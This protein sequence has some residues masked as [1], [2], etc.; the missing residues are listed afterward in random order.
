[1]RGD[2]IAVLT[3]SALAALL[4]VLMGLI[5]ARGRRSPAERER[6]RRRVLCQQGRLAEATVIDIQEH[7]ITY[8]YEIGGV[9]YDSSQDVQLF[10]ER[11][12]P[13]PSL[14]I[15]PAYVKYSARNP[16]ESILIA[17]DW[18]GIRSRKITK[19]HERKPKYDSK[20]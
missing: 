15:G 20:I 14:I 12:P 9:V 5:L 4:F 8:Q 19:G 10:Q 17:E 11:I 7:H 1:M 13:D 18:S 6:E 3:L 2:Q 16:Y